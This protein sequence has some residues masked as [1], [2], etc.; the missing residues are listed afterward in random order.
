[1]C[2]TTVTALLDGGD[3][4]GSPLTCH[5]WYAR[6]GYKVLHT[7]THLSKSQLFEFSPNMTLFPRGGKWGAEVKI[8]W[9]GNGRAR[10]ESQILVSESALSST[11]FQCLSNLPELYY[12]PSV[13]PSKPV[14]QDPI[15]HNLQTSSFQTWCLKSF[16]NF[17]SWPHPRFTVSPGGKAWESVF[18]RCL[19]CP[20]TGTGQVPTQGIPA[21]MILLCSQTSCKTL[22]VLSDF[23]SKVPCILPIPPLGWR[24][25]LQ[26]I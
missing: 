10:T 7:L 20:S 24:T 25:M 4:E 1:M 26:K 18:F 16:G 3:D 21:F 12:L 6:H 14:F 19:K 17:N 15:S 11:A 23:S 2:N 13:H 5:L 22:L 8:M 9:S